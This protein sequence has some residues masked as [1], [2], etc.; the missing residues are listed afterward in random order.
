[1]RALQRELREQVQINRARKRK[2]ATIARD[3][4][5]YQEYNQILEELDRQVEQSFARRHVSS[6]YL[7]IMIT[8]HAYMI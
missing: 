1:L 7:I 8:T 6:V 5:A 2:L 4:I 3:Y